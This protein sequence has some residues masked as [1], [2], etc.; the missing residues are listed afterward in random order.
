MK[1]FI[2]GIVLFILG[3]ASPKLYAQQPHPHHSIKQQQHIDKKRIHHGRAT[4]QL[5]P[6]EAAH[7]RMEQAKIEQYKDMAMADGRVNRKERAFIKQEQAK[8]GR[9]IYCQKHDRQRR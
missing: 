9:N 2:A 3:V 8:A 7:L 6:K 4:G 5:T 1:R